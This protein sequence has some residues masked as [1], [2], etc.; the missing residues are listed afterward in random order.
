MKEF[1]SK[2]NTQ[3]GG[4]YRHVRGAGYPIGTGRIARLVDG[5]CHQVALDRSRRSFRGARD[6]CV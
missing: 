4:F 1:L 3:I 5:I 6:N 2:H